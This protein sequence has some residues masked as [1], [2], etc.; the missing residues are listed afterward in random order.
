MT[1]T[2][3]NGE[4]NVIQWTEANTDDV[5]ALNTPTN[6]LVLAD[7]E[8]GGTDE[9]AQ[10]QGSIVNVRGGVG[11]VVRVLHNDWLAYDTTTGEITLVRPDA[12]DAYWSEVGV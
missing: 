4:F 3:R 5:L 6:F 1:W 7:L 9:G 12:F 11:T 8:P 10:F 2:P